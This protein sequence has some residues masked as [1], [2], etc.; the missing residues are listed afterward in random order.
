MPPRSSQGEL[1]VLLKRLEVDIPS[2]DKLDTM[3]KE[4]D[5]DEN[6]EI[7]YKELCGLIRNLGVVRTIDVA[8]V[9]DSS[10]TWLVRVCGP[11]TWRRR[12]NL[13]PTPPSPP[14]P[15]L[16][17]TLHTGAAQASN[18]FR[19]T[20]RAYLNERKTLVLWKD[21]FDRVDGFPR[22]GQIDSF[23]LRQVRIREQGQGKGKGRIRGRGRIGLPRVALGLGRYIQPEPEPRSDPYPLRLWQAF[24]Q[25]ADVSNLDVSAGSFTDV[26]SER[27]GVLMA[28]YDTDGDGQISFEEFK[29]KATDMVRPSARSNRTPDPATPSFNPDSDADADP[30]PGPGPGPGRDQV[31]SG[32]QYERA[33][34][35]QGDQTALRAE[36]ARRATLSNAQNVGLNASMMPVVEARLQ[37][38]FATSG[39]FNKAVGVLRVQDDLYRQFKIKWSGVLEEKYG[40]KVDD[41]LKP[42]P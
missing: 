33:V 3:C 7:N 6:G 16:T 24:D 29:A 8:Q 9:V 27:I 41:T 36:A 42:Q 13:D 28:K 34:A 20:L 17:R 38:A 23:E 25:M 5:E 39:T 12:A 22:N 11:P 19:D 2:D 14:S 1:L 40:Q 4:I 21:I 26:L 15:A 35:Q 18:S 31:A 30:G 37:A 10:G 32:V